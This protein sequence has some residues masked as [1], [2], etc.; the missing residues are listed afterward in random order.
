MTTATLGI[1]SDVRV[2]YVVKR[3]PRYSET[4]IV[5]EVL[6]HEE[7]GLPIEIFSLKPSND[8]HYQD[9][10]SRVRAPVKILPHAG[11]K[12]TTLWDSLCGGMRSLPGL[13]SRFSDAL[14]ENVSHVHQALVLAQ[15]IVDSKLSHVH[16]HFGTSPATVARLAARFADVSYS[17][18]A[19]AKDLYHDD[20]DR[21]DLLKRH[22]DHATIVTVSDFNRR[23]LVDEFGFRQDRVERIYNGLDLDRF[24]YDAPTMRPRRIIAIGRLIEKKGFDH[25]VDACGLLRDT[26]CAFE[27]RI[28]GMGP[29][30]ESIRK[31]IEARGLG[32]QVSLSGPLPQHDVHRELE[33]AAVF[34]APCVIGEDGDRD[35]VP[36]TLIEAMALGVPCV[37]TDVTGIPE[38]VK[39][40]ETGLVVPQRDP[41]ALAEAIRRLLDRSGERIKLS[42]AG[43]QHVEDLFDVR[44][45]T[46]ELREIF[47][48]AVAEHAGT[49]AAKEKAA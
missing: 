45:S 20:V 24:R 29:E 27:C 31:R 43:R 46:R 5:N 33:E 2:A 8:T 4:F 9:Q 25:L 13:P 12:A 17:F 38:L 3:Y 35:G 23:I 22:G 47:C 16:A 30:E 11:L 37:S 10:I 41:K 19:H 1:D 34:A 44:K 32:A 28:I 26:G 40:E 18:T 6:A 49:L 36:T 42:I 15:A 39:H 21:A 7:A 14:S 48:M